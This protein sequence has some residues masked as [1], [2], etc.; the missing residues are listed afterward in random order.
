MLSNSKM[1]PKLI[2]KPRTLTPIFNISFYYI[3]TFFSFSIQKQQCIK[4]SP[5]DVLWKKRSWKFCK[6]HWKTPAACLFFDKVAEVPEQEFSFE[7]SKMFKNSYF[8]KWLRRVLLIAKVWKTY[9]S[10]KCQKNSWNSIYGDH[11]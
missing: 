8:V 2:W 3:C 5:G 9:S 1:M 11:F 7:F 4:Q 6:T 10:R